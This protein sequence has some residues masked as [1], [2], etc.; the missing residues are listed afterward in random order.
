MRVR[1]NEVDAQALVYFAQHLTY[2]DNAITE[3]LRSL[4][5]DLFGYART[6]GLD[7]N[8]VHAEVDFARPVRLDDVLDV[9]VGVARLGTSS[10]TFATTLHPADSDDV[11]SR[12]S[13][14]WVH[15]DQGTMR[16]TPIPIDL[17]PPSR[18]APE[19]PRRTVKRRSNPPCGAGQPRRL[20][21]PAGVTGRRPG[22]RFRQSMVLVSGG[23]T[24]ADRGALE[25][26]RACAVPITGWCPGGRWTEAGPLERC[27]PLTPT[28]MRRPIQRTLRNL[29][30]ADGVLILAGRRPRGGSIV[31][32]GRPSSPARIVLARVPT[33]RVWRSGF[34]GGTGSDACWWA[35]PGRARN[36]ASAR[37]SGR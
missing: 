8:V 31:R 27:W 12:G 16:S 36:P 5:F 20:G 4:S 28:P 14:V 34:A 1:Y 9:A 7:F 21:L 35:V 15:A 18:T 10:V 22:P 25:A 37:R 11:L 29:R 23:Q 2:Y 32:P 30:L 6:S 33:R 24:G 13:V 26:A 19:H 17:P 3:F